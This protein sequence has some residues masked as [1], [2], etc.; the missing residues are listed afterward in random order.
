MMS[1][2]HGQLK[3]ALFQEDNMKP[4]KKGSGRHKQA[5]GKTDDKLSKS[6]SETET[7]SKDLSELEKELFSIKITYLEARLSRKQQ[8]CTFMEEEKQ[9]F[10][11]EYESK[12]VLKKESMA[13]LN[14]T[15]ED[16]YLE[17]LLLENELSGMEAIASENAFKKEETIRI[18]RRIEKLKRT[19][20]KLEKKLSEAE[21]TAEDISN[22]ILK[23]ENLEEQISK[24]NKHFEAQIVD[25]N[26]DFISFNKRLKDQLHALIEEIIQDNSLKLHLLP[27]TYQA[28]FQAGMLGNNWF[29]S[30]LET[31]DNL[32]E[33]NAEI[34][35]NI[36]Q[37][38]II[39]Q[40]SKETSQNALSIIILS[41]EAKELINQL[42]QEYLSVKQKLP[43][44]F[45]EY[46][47]QMNYLLQ[48][49]NMN[50]YLEQSIF[51]LTDKMESLENSIKQQEAL[52]EDF[53]ENS[54]LLQ[55][56]MEVKDVIL[57][58]L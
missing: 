17:L 46:K 48:L 15:Y 4:L 40:K 13:L 44:V 23:L 36:Y 19:E 41:N 18:T 8:L 3:I 7:V 14:Q 37:I 10:E 43:N 6:K 31:C 26:M 58:E 1:N 11:A 47:T 55:I 54:R 30:I 29:K 33:Q 16:F 9:F 45:Q 5:G 20:L 2:E 39:T 51:K 56:I 21:T 38:K 53:T 22:L 32:I 35:Q 57:K 34:N 42:D 50:M 24:K 27:Y 49:N 28:L 52:E 25:L 12:K